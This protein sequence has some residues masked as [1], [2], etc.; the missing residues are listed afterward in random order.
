MELTPSRSRVVFKD[1]LVSLEV[2][3]NAEVNELAHELPGS[4]ENKS[5]CPFYPAIDPVAP[6]TSG[7]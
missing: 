3:T 5:R 2:Q 1:A 6:D 7:S 4:L